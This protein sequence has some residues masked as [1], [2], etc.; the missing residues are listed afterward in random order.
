MIK[1][2][3]V[4]E[5]VNSLT[6]IAKEYHGTQQLR[7]HISREVNKLVK[8]EQVCIWFYDEPD[9]TWVADCGATWQFTEDGPKENGVNFCFKCGC[10]VKL[11]EK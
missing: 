8:N 5:C 4:S 3:L 9:Y 11:E 10:Q 1:D 2:H 7:A 6:K